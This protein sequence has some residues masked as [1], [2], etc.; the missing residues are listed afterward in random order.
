MMEKRNWFDQG[1]QSYAQYRPEYPEALAAFLAAAAPATRLAV[2]VGCGNGQLTT[3]LARHFAQV[4]GIDPSADQ[5]AHARAASGVAYA[6]APAEKLP[7]ADGVASAITAAQA[8]HW[9]DLPA[10]YAEVRRVAHQGA[11]VAL[12]SYGVLA[13]EGALGERFLRFYA[14]DIGPFWPPERRLVD[15]GYAGMD[16][17]FAERPAPAFAI[18]QAW[19]LGQFLGYVA[20]WSA[21]KNARQAGKGALLAAFADE[22]AALWGDAAE[23]KRVTW[24]LHMRLGWV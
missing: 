12:I 8:A 13:L 11:V 14:E 24:P 1:G 21:V 2:D 15:A 19:D 16:F 23:R 17:P 22:F 5:I 7:F 18:E 3:L 9:F 4:A 10:F 6:V 20:T